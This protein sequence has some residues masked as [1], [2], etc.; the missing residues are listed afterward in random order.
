VRPPPKRVDQ[1]DVRQP[2]RVTDQAVLTR[3]TT[4]AQRRESG[5]CGGRKADLQRPASQSGKHG[6]VVGMG[7]EQFRAQSVYQQNARAGDITG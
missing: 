5:D 1:A 2:E 4:G 7:V 3:P 6:R